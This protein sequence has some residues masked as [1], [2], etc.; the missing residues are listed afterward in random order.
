MPREFAN[1][2]SDIWGDDDWRDLSLRAQWLYELLMTHPTLTTAG[3]ADWRPAKLSGLARDATAA[4]IRE[5]AEELLAAWFVVYDD[6][7][8]EILIRSFLRHDGVLKKPNVAISMTKAFAAVASPEIRGVI[9][10]ELLRLSVEHPEWPA[11]QQD[12]VAGL[13]KKRSVDPKRDRSSDGSV[14]P[15]GNGYAKGSEN[16]P[17]LPVTSNPLPVTGNQD[18]SRPADDG[19]KRLAEV[20]LPESW[21]PTAGHF[22]RARDLG[23][24][25]AAEV[26]A[27]R[28]HAETHDRHAANWN[29]AFT[30][31][32]K[33]AGER[34]GADAPVLPGLKPSV[35]SDEQRSWLS[36]RG[37][38]EEEFLERKDEPGWLDSVKRLRPREV[39][40]V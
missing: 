6:E 37:V 8:E 38:S 10:H 36:A 3:V 23:V 40:H 14:D 1:M 28:L 11:W 13:L 16:D 33:K 31:W 5:A 12:R 7:T 34:R 35:L 17:S 24:D 4:V 21:A 20:R 32:L 15:S 26:D 29:A 2:R 18:A 9:V 39:A 19:K 25:V 22:A 27:F 30:T